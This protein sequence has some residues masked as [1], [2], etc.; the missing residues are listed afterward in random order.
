MRFE[1]AGISVRDREHEGGECTARTHAALGGILVTRGKLLIQAA[2]VADTAGTTLA[3]Q[4]PSSQENESPP[5]RVYHDP[6]AHLPACL[7]TDGSLT[8]DGALLR[9]N[10]STGNALAE[11]PATVK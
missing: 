7:R 3:S 10:P 6:R 8:S 1:T 4:F 2:S 9:S 11:L 5:Q